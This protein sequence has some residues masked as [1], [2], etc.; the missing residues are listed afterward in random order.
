MEHDGWELFQ[1]G[2]TNDPNRRIGKHHS[3]GWT[4]IEIRGPMDGSLAKS[5]ETSILLAL[6]ARGA[7]MANKTDIKQFDGWTEAWTQNSLSVTGFKQLLDWVY[8]DDQ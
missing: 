4:S 6:K 8:E 3:D 1:I 2:L 5:F 7:K